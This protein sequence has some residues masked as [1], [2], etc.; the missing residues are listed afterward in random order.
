[1]TADRALFG[2]AG[3]PQSFY[4]EGN[5]HSYQVPAWLAQRGLGWYEYSCGNGVSLSAATARRIGEAARE[6]GIGV[7]VHAPYYI[8][9]ANPDPEKRARSRE[10]IRQAVDICRE[11]G[12]VRVVFHPGAVMKR[13][14]EE[15]LAEALPEMERIVEENTDVREGRIALCPEVMGKI[16]QLGSLEEVL[17]LCAVSD[18]LVPCIDFGH[19]NCRTL[20][21]LRTREDYARVLDA[22]EA[23]LPGERS[24][25]FHA[26]FSHI[27][28][29][30]AGEVRHLTFADGGEPD[31]APLAAELAERGMTPVIVCE[32]AGTQAEDALAMQDR[33][34]SLRK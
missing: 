27:L 22:L 30:K 8:N 32:S 1:M 34:L 17:A 7:S 16:G 31:F 2:P 26:H 29:G 28:Y 25:A 19:L 15:A 24:R 4:D 13:T 18:R 6:A 23:A 21:S 10:Y 5:K 20:G 33:Y 14:R 3:N 9:F 12:G 11:M